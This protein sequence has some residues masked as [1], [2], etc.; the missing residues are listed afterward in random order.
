MWKNKKWLSGLLAVAASLL[1]TGCGEGYYGE[2]YY[3]S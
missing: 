1:L 3:E 2:N